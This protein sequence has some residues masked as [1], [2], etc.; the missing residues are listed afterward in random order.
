MKT[1]KNLVRTSAL[2]LL[3]ALLLAPAAQGDPAAPGQADL[4]E[5]HLPAPDAE[6]LPDR[7]EVG[8]GRLRRRGPRAA[9]RLDHGH[10]PRRHVPRPR[11]E[12]RAR[13]AGR[14][15]P[16]PRRDEVEDR[17][18]ARGAA[19]LPRRP[20]QLELRRRPRRRLPQPPRQGPRRGARDPARGAHRAPLP[21]RQAEAPQGP[22][23]ADM[24]PRND[25]TADIEGASGASS[26]SARATT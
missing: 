24:K 2:A 5:V 10:P 6:G 12:G 8:P 22:A 26:P 21:G 3:G 18:A 11:R 17:R 16:R 1:M 7:P 23:P 25:D 14:L 20:A 19:R 9:A 13:R 15:P 4:P